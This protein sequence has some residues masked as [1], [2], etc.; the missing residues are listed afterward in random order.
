MEN[1]WILK[2]I[3]RYKSICKRISLS[4]FLLIKETQSKEYA[5]AKND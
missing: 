1:K 2:S 3:G 4:V 5:F